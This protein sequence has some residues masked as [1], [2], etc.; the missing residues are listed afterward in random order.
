MDY[1]YIDGFGISPIVNDPIEVGKMIDKET[2]NSDDF[3]KTNKIRNFK[4]MKID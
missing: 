1:D 3:K 4:S 2:E